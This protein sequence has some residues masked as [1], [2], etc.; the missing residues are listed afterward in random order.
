MKKI[1]FLTYD[2]PYPFNSG[3]KI[4]AFNMLAQSGMAKNIS[5][6]SFTR[7][8]I[9]NRQLQKVKELGISSIHV[10]ERTAH[11]PIAKLKSVISGND[12]IFYTLYYSA[13]VEKKIIEIIE[14][15]SIDIVH[16][17]SFYTGYYLNDRIESTGVKTVFGSE[18]IEH[19]LYQDYVASSVHPFIRPVYKREVQKIKREELDFVARADVTVAVSQEEADYFSSVYA[20]RVEIVE[21]G[22]DLNFFTY[23]NRSKKDVTTILF[24]G[25]FKYFPNIEAVKFLYSVYKKLPLGKYRLMVI[26]KD[27]EKL[28]IPRTREIQ[29]I[30]YIEDIRDAYRDADIFA[31]PVTLGGGTNFKILE[32]M[33]TGV[34]VI[35]HPH[36]LNAF[37][38]KPGTH[39]IPAESV[40]EYV[41]SI[42]RIASHPQQKTMTKSARDFVEKNYSWSTVGAKL[43]KVWK[44][45]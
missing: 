45:I 21:N 25:N 35:G 6:F 32:A 42:E 38:V 27:A 22:I 40:D 19:K 10:S 29:L 4:R 39:Y 16:A 15:E 11:S 23:E 34:P 13:D 18:N 26:G 9:S 1:L 37:G 31:F 3:G 5:L 17:E 24:V 33:A 44:S 20:K 43:A 30:E 41:T 2:F 8:P 12:S 36:R 14:K 7:G 28:P